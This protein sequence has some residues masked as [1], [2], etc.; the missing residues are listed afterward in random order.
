M[1]LLSQVT[2]LVRLGREH[3]DALEDASVV[4]ESGG[5]LD[6]VLAAFIEATEHKVDDGV[7]LA[8]GS[9]LGNLSNVLMNAAELLAG[10]VDAA[11]KTHLA[12]S[13]LED[14]PLREVLGDNE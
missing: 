1:S 10:V 11:E 8:V 5:T 3:A 9:V 7:R 14:R 4:Y 6:D 12:L 2:L 13:E